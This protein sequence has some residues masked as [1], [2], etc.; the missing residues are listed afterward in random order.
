M[1]WCICPICLYSA[2]CEVKGGQE[3]CGHSCNGHEHECA[4]S[5]HFPSL[6]EVSGG[7]SSFAYVLA[8]TLG[9]WSQMARVECLSAF[10]VL[11]GS[12]FDCCPFFLSPN[13]LLRPSFPL[14]SI[15][16]RLCFGLF[17]SPSPTGFL[18]NSVVGR[19][20]G[21]SK[22]RLLGSLCRNASWKTFCAV[23]LKIFTSCLKALKV[24]ETSGS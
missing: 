13:S 8:I 9:K 14:L 6:L 12:L 15:S 10:P 4:V 3:D 17:W 16:N 21:W 18:G 22:Q 2:M 11:I 7:E 20:T 5:L 1:L 24:E 19:W 23:A